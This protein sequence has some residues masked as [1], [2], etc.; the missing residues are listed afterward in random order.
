MS[1]LILPR[2]DKDGNYYI[3]YSQFSSWKDLKGF[4]TN[5]KGS[6]EYMLSYFFGERFEDA[7]WSQ[8]GTEVEGYI[9]EREFANQF[10]AKEKATLDSI[11]PLGV[12]QHEVKFFVLPN[13]YILGYIDD[14]L[15]DFSKIRDY[16]TAS[17]SSKAKYYKPDYYQLDIY[18][19]YVKEMFGHYPQAEVC[20]IERVG[21]CFG[22]VQRRDLLSVGSFVLYHQREVS[23]ERSLEVRSLLLKTITEIS[24]AYKLYLK[25][26]GKIN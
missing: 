15:E 6:A 2:R 14:A 10:T 20:I 21:N 4:N 11:K 9:T 24:D 5:M 26:N 3:S 16:K 22:K 19:T 1:K 25:L 23:E 8:F 17:K 12:F 7:G 18:A 13:V